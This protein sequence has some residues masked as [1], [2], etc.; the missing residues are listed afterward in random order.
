[1]DLIRGLIPPG[2]LETKIL[3]FLVLTAGIQEL[4]SANHDLSVY[5]HWRGI[6][7]VSVE[8]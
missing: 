4:N 3:P 8:R 6:P 2:C 7:S 1:M 5:R